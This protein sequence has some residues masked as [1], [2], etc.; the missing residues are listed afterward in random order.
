MTT[1]VCFHAGGASY[2]LPVTETRAVRRAVGII[3]IPGA[4]FNV[5]GL[6][7][8]DPPLSVLSP[9]GTGGDHVLVIEADAHTFGLQ[10]DEVTGLC[11]VSDA[12]I[13]PA[14]PGQD[15]ALISGTVANGGKL[16]MVTSATALAALL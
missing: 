9:L 11:Q 4:R 12:D 8:G 1:M 15:R 7:P 13:R 16:V 10:V 14:P 3:E 5:T 2:C 6:I